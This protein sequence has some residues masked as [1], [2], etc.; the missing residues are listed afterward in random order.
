MKKVLLA[1]LF[2]AFSLG[3]SAQ[4]FEYVPLDANTGRPLVPNVPSVPSVPSIQSYGFGAPTPPR[5]Q[6]SV[7]GG[8]V[9]AQDGRFVRVKIRVCARIGQYEGPYVVA[10]YHSDARSWMNNGTVR[11]QRVSS[12]DGQFIVD[13][14]EWSAL[15]TLYGTV[16]FQL[17]IFN[18][19]R[20][21]RGRIID[22]WYALVYC[23]FIY[24]AIFCFVLP[25]YPLPFLA[26]MGILE[27]SKYLDCWSSKLTAVLRRQC[28]SIS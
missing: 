27:A 28:F 26:K 17:L 7:V 4:A 14:F 2:A 25:T 11:A 1:T 12:G 24:K 13:N 20:K 18:S 8:Y 10:V 3:M 9:K 21:F 22:L 19:W 23:P 16:I 6:T 15:T 5:S